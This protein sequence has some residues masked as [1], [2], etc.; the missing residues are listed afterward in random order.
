MSMV[1]CE[2]CDFCID[3]D[4]DCECFVDIVETREEGI[5]VNIEAILCGRCREDLEYE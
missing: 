5:S 1:R 3:S 2:G 4:F